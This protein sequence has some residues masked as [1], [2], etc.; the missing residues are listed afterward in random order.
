MPIMI[1]VESTKVLARV[2]QASTIK[3]LPSCSEKQAEP[4]KSSEI[5]VLQRRKENIGT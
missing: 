5:S 3:T 1:K 2:T 4:L